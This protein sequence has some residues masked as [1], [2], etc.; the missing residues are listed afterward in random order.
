M[1]PVRLRVEVNGSD[2]AAANADSEL[3]QSVLTGTRGRIAA[4]PLW[5][6]Q[7]IPPDEQPGQKDLNHPQ[8]RLRARLGWHPF[9]DQDRNC[10]I[11]RNV[12]PPQQRRKRSLVT[13]G[14]IRTTRAVLDLANRRCQAR[15]QSG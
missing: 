9:V 10:S 11:T 8:D 7:D 15:S 5:I 6:L 14:E 3:S 12:L 1:D 4:D 2:D 13:V